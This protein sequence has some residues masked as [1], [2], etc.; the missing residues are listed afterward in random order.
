MHTH[1]SVWR[2]PNRQTKS[3]SAR[4]NGRH[5]AWAGLS[6]ATPPL[7]FARF[8]VVP[9]PPPAGCAVV[10]QRPRLPFF[11]TGS[12]F[13]PGSQ[14]I[15]P[16]P[17]PARPV[18]GLPPLSNGGVVPTGPPKW[19]PPPPPL[20]AQGLRRFV[21][22]TRQRCGWAAAKKCTRSEEETT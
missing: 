1:S 16:K 7:N 13:P 5:P 21:L 2:I 10:S 4:P 19:L 22:D 11:L 20:T 9:F 14:R 3:E 18:S 17:F 6:Q 8:F 15:S 12:S